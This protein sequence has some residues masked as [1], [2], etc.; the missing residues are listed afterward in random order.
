MHYPSRRS[1]KRTP[2]DDAEASSLC[3]IRAPFVQANRHGSSYPL[4]F[5]V[6][7]SLRDTSVSHQPL[8]TWYGDDQGVFLSQIYSAKQVSQ[9]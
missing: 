6:R 7:N 4:N 1:S 9:E 3:H 2:R 8:H 5:G